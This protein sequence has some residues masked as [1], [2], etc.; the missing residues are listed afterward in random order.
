MKLL[1][2]MLLTAATLLFAPTMTLAV[3]N[4]ITA[5]CRAGAPEAFSRPGGFCA[6]V[7]SNKSLADTT[8]H[9][10][11]AGYKVNNAPPPKCLPL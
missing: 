8:D 1:I 10:C 4:T 7:A 3:D 2:A 6:Q 9:A 5:N 11:P